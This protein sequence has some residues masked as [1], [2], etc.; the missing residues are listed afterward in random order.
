MAR[1]IGLWPMLESGSFK[2]FCEALTGAALEGPVMRQVLCL[3]PLDYSGPH[4][5]HHPEEER[6]R[7]GYVDVHL[8]FTTPGVKEQFIVYEKDGHLGE[9]R[10]IAKSGTVTAYRLP[11]WH[12]TTPL[13]TK[14]PEDR[15]WL[16][17]GTFLFAK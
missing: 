1:S 3:R 6:M 12:Y 17:L 4:T 16:V 7:D 11:V 15:R 9:L 10:S 5:D 2:V 14:R 13:V 8:T